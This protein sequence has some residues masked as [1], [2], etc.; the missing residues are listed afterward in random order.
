MNWGNSHDDLCMCESC[1]NAFSR[2]LENK[3]HT[4]DELNHQWGTSF[5]SQE[6]DDFS[7][8]PVP[9]KTPTV[10]NPSMLLDWKR[11]CSDLVIDFQNMQISIIRKIS[12]NQKN[13]T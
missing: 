6:Y 10:H 11:F 4:I 2:W 12:P 7:Q 5:W 8:I 1:K 3:Y 13:Y 9:R